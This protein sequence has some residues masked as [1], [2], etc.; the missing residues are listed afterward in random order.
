MM[1]LLVVILMSII[2]MMVVIT[3]CG[4]DYGNNDSYAREG[5]GD[6]NCQDVSSGHICGGHKSSDDG[7]CDDASHHLWCPIHKWWYM[8]FIHHNVIQVYQ[9]CTFPPH[10]HW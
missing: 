1:V 2:I 5:S 6:N 4:S 9:L 10:I 3:N 8:F 7:S